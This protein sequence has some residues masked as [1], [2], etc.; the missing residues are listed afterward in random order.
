MII[1]RNWRIG[2]LLAAT[3]LPLLAF[4]ICYDRE[5]RRQNINHVLIQATK[6]R[7]TA[8]AVALLRAGADANSVDSTYKPMNLGTLLTDIRHRLL[9]MKPATGTGYES[10]GM[11]PG[12]DNTA[13]MWAA[14][15]SDAKLVRELLYRGARVNTQDHDGITALWIATERGDL[16]TSTGAEA[17]IVRQLLE[18]NARVD[19]QDI[20]GE[21]VFGLIAEMERPDPEIVRL[22]KAARKQ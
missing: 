9:G 14:Y 12:T 10:A 18:R 20:H 7:D 22:L 11:V 15:Q 6:K 13:L 3:V 4:E 1:R 19:L 21:S 17:D 8:T 5:A 2:V 16:A